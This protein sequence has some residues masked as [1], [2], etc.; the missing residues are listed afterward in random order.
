MANLLKTSDLELPAHMATGLFDQAAEGSS[1]ALLSA[2]KPM[3]FGEHEFLDF[4]I[5]EAEFVDEG[6]AKDS[7]SVSRKT[8][9][10]KPYKAQITVRFNQEVQWADEDTQLGV[11]Q[12]VSDQMAPKLGRALDFGICHGLNPATGKRVAKMTEFLGGTANSVPVATGEAIDHIDAAEALLMGRSPAVVA[13]G[14]AIDPSYAAKFRQRQRNLNGDLLAGRLFPDFRTTL[15]LSDI[16]GLR[17]TVN[18]TISAK[19]ISPTA[20]TK[21]AGFMGPWSA[22]IYWGV[23]RRVGLETILYGDPDGQGDLKRHN[24]LAIR[25]EVVYGWVI[26]D[27]NEFVKF[28]TA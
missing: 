10:A 8:K 16:D 21:V 17:A 2:S 28:T 23:Q 1:V 4:N 11:L 25:A 14:I 18:D 26:R 19:G 20:P 6:A 27:V 3:L 15:A 9:R 13:D 7:T 24:Q 5:G 12:S 22:G